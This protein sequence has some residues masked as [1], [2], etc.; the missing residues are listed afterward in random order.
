VPAPVRTSHPAADLKLQPIAGDKLM[1]GASAALRTALDRAFAE[2]SEPPY[3]RTTAV[4]ILK[5]GQ[6]VAERYAHGVGVNTPVL[7]FSAT[8]S[9]T[10]ALLGI[11]V[12]QGKLD[13]NQPAAFAAWAD[14]VDSRHAITP[15]QLLRQTS[16]LD[17][18][19]DNSGF[20]RNTRM[21]YLE[22]DMAGFAMSSR[23]LHPPGT[24][25][26]YA[27]GNF[28]LL[29]RLVRDAVGGT[30]HDVAAFAQR[31]L[32]GPLGMQHAV[33]EF[34][35]TGTPLGSSYFLATGRD[36]ARFGQLYLN[37]GMAGN[38]RILPPGWVKYSATQ[39]LDTGYGAGFWVN[40]VPG[41]AP[42]GGLWGMPNVPKD[43]FFAMGFMGQHVVVV[44]SEQLV[45]VR[46]GVSHHYDGLIKGMDRLVAD[47]IAAQA[48][49]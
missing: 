15:D 20:D 37:D 43:A 36:W 29:S 40:G 7:G 47:V 44:P 35:A 45:V 4:L 24:Q 18:Y 46:L 13:M 8:K 26:A 19:Q 33:L 28:I 27:D 10:N 32:F 30:A 48:K 16:G 3:I 25:W 31:E 12:R 39:T 41:N 6:L 9:I 11:L 14:P 5:N 38:Q 2:R 34:D 42:W 17:M 1:D 22:R 49:P 23:L 21:M